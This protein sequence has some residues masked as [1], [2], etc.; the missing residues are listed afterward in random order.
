MCV[1]DTTVPFTL[2]GQ[3]LVLEIA[4]LLRAVP[5]PG[6]ISVVLPPTQVGSQF[7]WNSDIGASEG[8]VE[9]KLVA[10]VKSIALL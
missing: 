7:C 4:G 10:R 6:V 1:A 5:P 9:I 8:R 2:G 3:E